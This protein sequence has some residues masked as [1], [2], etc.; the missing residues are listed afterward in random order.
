MRMMSQVSW[1]SGIEDDV[2]VTVPLKMAVWGKVGV[3]VDVMIEGGKVV[4]QLYC[5]VV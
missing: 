4:L 3:A 5:V 2:T 1:H